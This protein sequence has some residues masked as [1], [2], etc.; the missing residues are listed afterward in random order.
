MALLWTVASEH[1]LLNNIQIMLNDVQL[2][3]YILLYDL[4]RLRHALMTWGDKFSG[5]EVDDAYDNFE[6]DDKGFINT[7]KL[8][9]LLTAAAEEEEEGE[10]A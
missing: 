9:Q 6:I 10:A 5:N 8:I 4:L 2:V 3:T 7:A 1:K